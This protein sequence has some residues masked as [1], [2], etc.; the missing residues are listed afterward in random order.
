MI[1]FLSTGATM[2]QREFNVVELARPIALFGMFDEA[3]L[4]QVASFLKEQHYH[5]GDIIF[6]QGDPGHCLSLIASGRVRIYLVGADGGE[7]TLRIYGEGSHFG[8]F[9]VIDGAPRSASTSAVGQLNLLRLVS[10]QLSL[11]EVYAEAVA[12][13]RHGLALLCAD[14]LAQTAILLPRP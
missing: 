9:S 8:E 7:V 14:S 10:T 6:Q 12:R 3:Q 13:R 5:K 11:S 2:V 1:L 4:R